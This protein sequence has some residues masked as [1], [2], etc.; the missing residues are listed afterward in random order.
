MVNMAIIPRSRVRKITNHVQS[1]GILKESWLK[2]Y[3]PYRGTIGLSCSQRGGHLTR[4]HVCQH[5]GGEFSLNCNWCPDNIDHLPRRKWQLLRVDSMASL[6]HWAVS[7]PQ[8]LCPSKSAPK[9][10]GI[11]QAALGNRTRPNCVVCIVQESI[12]PWYCRFLWILSL[13]RPY[14]VSALL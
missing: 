4:A 6:P 8:T 14:D 13:A 11:S 10:P 1:R 3:L 9:S 12:S 7:P 2:V 5:P